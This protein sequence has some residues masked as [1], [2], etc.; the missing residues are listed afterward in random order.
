MLFSGG[1]AGRDCHWPWFYTFV[2]DQGGYLTA[3]I[4][5]Y[6]F[7]SL[8][9]LLLMLVTALGFALQG[10]AGLQ[11]RVL[12]SALAHFPVIGVGADRSGARRRRGGRQ[13]VR[14][15]GTAPASHAEDFL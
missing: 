5:Y 8:F 7:V 4:T 3:L 2:D 1:T 15:P 13:A 12:D 14:A 9:L 6:G 10:S 11:Q